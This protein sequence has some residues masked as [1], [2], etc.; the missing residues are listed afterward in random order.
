M[1]DEAVDYAA[2]LEA[3]GLP[4][5]KDRSDQALAIIRGRHIEDPKLY[6]ALVILAEQM[7]MLTRAISPITRAITKQAP[8]SGLLLPPTDFSY[9]LTGTTVRLSWTRPPI[10]GVI[11]YEIRFGA[12]SWEDS[13][14][15]VR[16]PSTTVDVIPFTGLVGTYRI[17]T[18]NSSDG[19]YSEL[20]DTVLVT[21]ARPGLMSINSSVIDNNVL[22]SWVDPVVGS[23]DIAFYS[24][25]KDNVFKGTSKGTFISFFEV[26]SGT[27]KYSII[28]VDIADNVGE[29]SEVELTINQPPD[30]ALQDSRLSDLTGIRVNVP[31]LLGPKL[32][33]SWATETWEQHFMTRAWINIKAQQ[34]AGYPIYIQPTTINGSYEEIYDYGTVFS[35]VI[36]SITWQSNVI[37]GHVDVVVYMSHSQDGITYTP[38]VA[39]ASQ[40]IPGMRYLKF[41]LEFTGED[42]KSLMEV[43]NVRISLDVKRENDGG[44]FVALATDV[45][46]TK[47]FFNK[48]F[49]DVESITAT[50]DAIEPLT[51]IYDFVDIPD[52]KFFYVYVL[53]STGNRVTYLISWKARGIV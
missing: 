52:P 28:P 38:F 50:A 27:Y 42:D 16:T 43:F 30:Y 18:M 10:I 47:I 34:L 3:L 8:T 14:F 49:K 44:D 31:L 36:A 21:V 1:A 24:L 23:F 48:P 5:I 32:L 17:K 33:C 13:D 40:F 41:R 4:T 15:V 51:V 29:A 37:M 26:I 9:I 6:E 46:G 39:G 7:G 2:A 53:D 20:E 22:L 11:L 35:N 25:Y 19:V 45:G 12:N